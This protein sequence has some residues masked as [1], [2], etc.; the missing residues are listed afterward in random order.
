MSLRRP[1]LKSH[2]LS[3]WEFRTHQRQ[4]NALLSFK[5]GCCLPHRVAV[6]PGQ[7]RTPRLRGAGTASRKRRSV[8]GRTTRFGKL[9][10]ATTHV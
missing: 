4:G 10:T 5:R 7:H 9:L 3:L 6:S 2:T 8:R 1:V